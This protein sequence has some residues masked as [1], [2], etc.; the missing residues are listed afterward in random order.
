MLQAIEVTETNDEHGQFAFDQPS[1]QVSA[2][3]KRSFW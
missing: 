2:E 3:F 1:P